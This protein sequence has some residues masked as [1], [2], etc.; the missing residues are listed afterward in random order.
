MEALS[1][2]SWMGGEDAARTLL[3]V[4]SQKTDRWI[5][6][7]LNSAVLLLKPNVESLIKAG[8]FDADEEFNDWEVK[9]EGGDPTVSTLN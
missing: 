2:A 4:A 6:N 3:T 9:V 8:E 1:A 5:R 7:A